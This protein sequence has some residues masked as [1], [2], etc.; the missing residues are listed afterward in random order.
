MGVNEKVLVH[1][2]QS[3]LKTLVTLFLEDEITGMVSKP[4]TI[5]CDDENQI[6]EIELMV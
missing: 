4:R 6:K 5:V 1:L 3:H 2:G